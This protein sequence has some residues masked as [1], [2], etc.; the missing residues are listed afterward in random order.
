MPALNIVCVKCTSV[1]DKATIADV[2]VDLCPKCG[3]IWLDKGE[4]TRLAAMADDTLAD[5]RGALLGHQGP[6]PVPADTKTP[7]PACDGMLKEVVLGPVVVEYCPQC[8]GIFLD[9]GELD[10]AVTAVRDKGAG[11]RQVLAVAARTA[12]DG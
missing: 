8:H 2:E 10:Q 11:A 9:R 3:G 12:V 1:L 6:P 5:L 7:C 4:I